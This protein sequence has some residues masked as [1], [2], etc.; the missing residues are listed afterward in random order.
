MWIRSKVIQRRYNLK[1]KA[2]IISDLHGSSSQRFPVDEP[3][4]VFILGDLAWKDVR[5]ID[6]MYLCPKFGVLGNHDRPDLYED[7]SIINLHA[8]TIKFKGL[9]IAGF[10]GCPTYNQ[11]NYGQ[12]RES[13]VT[14][15]IDTLRSP[16]DIFIAHSNPQLTP[17]L[18]FKDSHRGFSAFTKMIEKF[19][20]E[21][22]LH[23]HL[24]E[25]YFEKYLKTN[26]IC[27]HGFVYYDLR[28][29]FK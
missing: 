15:F 29:M 3:D 18:N 7:T 6:S 24:H 13:D 14:R 19:K 16:I 8:T 2:L 1:I 11:R 9:T 28:F 23:G 12:Y 25:N 17:C 26:L 10:G 27:V 22:F 20:P 5:Q 21:Y 4:I